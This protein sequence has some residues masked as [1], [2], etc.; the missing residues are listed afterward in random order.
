MFTHEEF[1]ARES[2]N[3]PIPAQKPVDEPCVL[4]AED[5]RSL[6]RYLE[7]VLRRAGYDVVVAADGLEAMRVTL[8]TKVDVVVTDA[9][10]PNLNGY[11]L[12][13][14]L[15]STSHLSHIPIVLLSALEQKEAPPE[16]QQADAYLAK[17]ISPEDLI[18]CLD[19]LLLVKSA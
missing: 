5:D 16:D 9:I 10:M 1:T 2:G 11:E 7:V 19:S 8:T 14:F 18:A 17:P 15:R 4:L 6:R 12:L 13:R 3:A